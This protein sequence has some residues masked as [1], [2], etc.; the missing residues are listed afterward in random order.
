MTLPDGAFAVVED[1]LA[2]ARASRYPVVLILAW[3]EQTHPDLWRPFADDH[4][5]HMLDMIEESSGP[6]FQART[7]SWP[8]LV[9]W[10]RA[11]AIAEG[12]CFVVGLDAVLTK[13]TG[14]ERLRALAKLLKSETRGPVTREAAPVVA[15]SSLAMAMRFEGESREHGLVVG[16]PG[17]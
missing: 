9:D 1:A 10:I 13:W 11:V 5:L 6:D 7:G 2:R 16:L 3:P 14:Q 15:L 8:E 17:R 4:G 12:G